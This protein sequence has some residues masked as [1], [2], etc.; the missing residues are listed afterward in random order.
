MWI[1]EQYI[2]KISGRVRN[3]RKKSSSLWN[4]SCPVCGDS[5]RD[6]YKA[7]GY[8]FRVQES[9][10]YKCHNCGAA[11]SFKAFL[12]NEFPDLAQQYNFEKF[13][14]NSLKCEEVSVTKKR[15]IAEQGVKAMF[16]QETKTL[17][18]KLLPRVSS[19]PVGHEAVAYVRARKIPRAAWDRMYYID[20]FSKIAKRNSGKSS[21]PRIIF[22]FFSRRGE[23][24]GLT[25]R[26][27]TNT[28]R[29]KYMVVRLKKDQPA[30]FGI[31]HVNMNSTIYV[32]EGPIDS[33]FLPNAIAAGSSDFHA[34]LS[35]IPHSKAVLVLDNQPRNPQV[36]NQYYRWAKLGYKIFLWDEDFPHKDLNECVENGNMSLEQVKD[37]V[38]RNTYEGLNLRLKLAKWSK[39]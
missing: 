37:M 27:I 8:I 22:P 5:K 12:G 36:V 39:V 1:E 19:L 3:F 11:S 17:L 14:E 20:D 6:K 18:D 9:Y 29:S 33:F 31:E 15:D 23:F 38:D 16:E 26:D 4:F 30:V 21:S 32:V 13:K 35:M 34:A 10:F 2:S 25:A 28:E 7:R 24:L